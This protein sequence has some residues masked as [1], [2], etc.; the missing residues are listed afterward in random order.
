MNLRKV[1]VATSVA[2]SAILLSGC[3]VFSGLT[4]ITV[5]DGS[6]VALVRMCGE[7]TS[8]AVG[9]WTVKGND[10]LELWETAAESTADVDL[11]GLATVLQLIGD[12]R[13]DVSAMAS[14]GYTW[15][16]TFD[17]QDLKDL[18]SGSVLINGSRDEQPEA[19][20]RSEFD[21]LVDDECKAFDD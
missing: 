20:T 8:N 14:G 1:S 13:V 21:D 4:G 7:T 10:R 9:L 18:P 19:L 2:A 6:V 16:V 3:S 17:D 11:G 12:R 5:R 15:D